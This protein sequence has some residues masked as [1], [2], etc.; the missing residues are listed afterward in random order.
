MMLE[1]RLYNKII[2]KSEGNRSD[3]IKPQLLRSAIESPMSPFHTNI[4]VHLIRN[5]HLG[6]E[7]VAPSL[8]IELQKKT[9]HDVSTLYM[10]SAI[11]NDKVNFTKFQ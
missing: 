10:S 5:V 4:R 9:G 11:F 7:T 1:K 6:V 3:H 2:C 8:F